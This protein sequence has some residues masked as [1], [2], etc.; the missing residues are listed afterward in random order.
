MSRNRGVVR[1]SLAL[2]V[3]VGILV[4]TTY[5]ALATGA[6]SVTGGSN[7]EATFTGGFSP[8]AL[9]KTEPT[10]VAFRLSSHFVTPD[11]THPPA[12]RELVVEADKNLA[13]N[14]RG[15]PVCSPIIYRTHES[16]DPAQRCRD[17][18]VG[19][20]TMDIEIAFPEATPISLRSHAILFNMGRREGVTKLGFYSY[21]TIPTPAAIVTDVQIRKVHNGRFGTEAVATIPKVAGG[22]G[23]VTAFEFKID[24]KYVYR[25]KR[26]SVLT[27]RC[28]DGKILTR[29]KAVFA[30]GLSTQEEL[31]RPCTPSS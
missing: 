25:G 10:P 14:V 31:P 3:L 15:Y 12:L 17:A 11:G 27:L 5:A 6:G 1:W 26:V 21:I 7:L 22:S 24:R 23:S 18:I 19:R 2:V 30:D 20:G 8:S 9:S 13:V 29:A 28:P 4:T 16:I